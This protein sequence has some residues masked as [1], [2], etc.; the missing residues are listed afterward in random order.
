MADLVQKFS[1]ME[2]GSNPLLTVVNIERLFLNFYSDLLTTWLSLMHCRCGPCLHFN[3]WTSRCLSVF[4][5]LKCNIAS[6][7]LRVKDSTGSW[8]TPTCLHG[9]H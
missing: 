6:E 5:A 1:R 4:R 9:L 7:H 3:V 2:L 8:F